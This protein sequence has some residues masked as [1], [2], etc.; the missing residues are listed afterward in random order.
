MTVTRVGEFTFDDETSEVCGPA[1][2]IRSTEYR[3]CIASIEGGTHYT[4]R[5]ACEHS[6]DFVT[7]LL[8]TIQTDYAGWHG[9]QVFNRQRGGK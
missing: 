7:A 1:E 9:M 2:Y 8:V 5:A 6:P 4:F 3:R